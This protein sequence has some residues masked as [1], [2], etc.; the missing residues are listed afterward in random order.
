MLRDWVKDT[1][2]AMC[3]NAKLQLKCLDEKKQINC[4]IYELECSTVFLFD[5]LLQALAETISLHFKIQPRR[6][7]WSNMTY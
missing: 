7:N 5:I 1:S 6:H 2:I 3:E 4:S